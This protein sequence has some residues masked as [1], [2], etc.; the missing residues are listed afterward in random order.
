MSAARAETDLKLQD[1]ARQ[2]E[3]ATITS[4]LSKQELALARDDKRAEAA[5]QT[6]KARLDGIRNEGKTLASG[7][8][9][10]SVTK[11]AQADGFAAASAQNMIAAAMT[12]ADA[13]Y[14]LTCRKLQKIYV[15]LEGR[16]K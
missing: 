16:R 1:I 11:M 14:D 10:K 13:Q 4:N 12:R 8:A 2:T 3:S 6:Q 15:I 9:G 7:Q 5:F